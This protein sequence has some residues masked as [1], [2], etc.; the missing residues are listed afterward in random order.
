MKCPFPCPRIDM[1]NS[2]QEHAGAKLKGGFSRMDYMAR[3]HAD[4]PNPSFRKLDAVLPV[5][6]RCGRPLVAVRSCVCFG[7][8]DGRLFTAATSR[9]QRPRPPCASWLKY[10]DCVSC[11][12]RVR[13]PYRSGG[14]GVFR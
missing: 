14:R 1:L 5:G 3:K 9:L 6:A 12:C 11:A 8:E 10:G 13:P 7:P 2:Y 4:M